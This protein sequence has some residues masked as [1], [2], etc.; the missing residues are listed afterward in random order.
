MGAVLAVRFAGMVVA[1]ELL[2]VLAPLEVVFVVLSMVDLALS[3]AEGDVRTRVPV[4]LRGTAFWL[5][6][7]AVCGETPTAAG[8]AEG[9]VAGAGVCAKTPAA[10]SDRT[11]ARGISFK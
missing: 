10:A 7:A 3:V 1:V 5:A 6:S 4:S 9:M 2:V 11:A 8:V